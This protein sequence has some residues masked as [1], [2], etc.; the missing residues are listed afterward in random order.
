VVTTP[1]APATPLAE[2]IERVLNIADE[3]KNTGA[4]QATDDADDAALLAVCA[5]ASH[6]CQYCPAH[7]RGMVGAKCCCGIDH[8][9]M[10]LTS[11][12]PKAKRARATT[13]Q[14][15]EI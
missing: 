9:C 1:P 15:K 2:A 6:A 8:H 13:A 11:R 3:I 12:T 7:A 10:R 4:Y 14:P 5:A